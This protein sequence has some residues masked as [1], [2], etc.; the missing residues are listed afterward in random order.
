MS[1]ADPYAQYTKPDRTRFLAGKYR[2]GT[3]GSTSPEPEARD[4]SPWIGPSHALVPIRSTDVIVR[5]IVV[6][7]VHRC[8][9]QFLTVRM[10]WRFG[11]RARPRPGANESDI[12]DLLRVATVGTSCNIVTIQYLRSTLFAA[13][14]RTDSSERVIAALHRMHIICL[15][16]SIAGYAIA[17]PMTQCRSPWKCRF[18]VL[19]AS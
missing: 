12:P 3:L 8:I 19:G 17:W 7:T 10:I 6:S 1:S 2:E 16:Y 15:R 13:D 5:S 11:R 9:E 14:R 4:R 18:E